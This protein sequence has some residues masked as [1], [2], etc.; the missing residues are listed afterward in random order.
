MARYLLRALC[1]CVLGVIGSARADVG[2]ARISLPKGPGSI[3]GL[4]GADFTAQLSSGQASYSIPV[5][6]PPAARSFGPNLTLAYDSGAGVSEIALGWRLAGTLSIRR[7]TQDG[8]PRFDESD[9]FEVVGLGSPSELLEVGAGV[10]RPRFEDGTF[11]QV[12]R[13]GESWEVRTKAGTTHLLGQARLESEDGEVVAYLLDRSF[14]ARGHTVSYEWRTDGAY[15]LLERVVWNDFGR[16]YLN[17]VVFTYEERPDPTRLYSSGIRQELSRRLARI[18]VRHGGELVRRYELAF[19]DAAH[20]RLMGVALVGSDG[21]T[22]LPSATFRYSESSW[23]DED[24]LA[25]IEMRGSPGRAPGANDASLVDLNGDALPDLLVGVAGDYSSALN[26]DGVTWAPRRAWQASQSPSFSL[27]SAGVHLADFDGDGAADLLAASGER[28]RYLA[29]SREDGFVREVELDAQLALDLGA[30]NVRLADF[31]GDRRIDIGLTTAS[32]LVVA[33]NR[34]GLGF[35]AGQMAR[36][37]DP[38][39]PVLF[40]SE[41]TDLCDINGDR[42]LDVCRLRSGSLVYYLGRGRGAFEAAEKGRGVPTFEAS[43]AFVLRDLDGDGW[44]DLVRIRRSEVSYAL[45]IGEG[46]FGAVRSIGKVPTQAASTRTFFADMNGSGSLDI[47]WVD[48]EAEVP[49]RYLE[50]FPQ[51][52]AGLL[53]EADGGL[54]KVQRLEYASAAAFAAKD[55]A[56]LEAWS[57]RLNVALPV[58]ARRTVETGLGDP[59]LVQEYE[60]TDGTYDPHERTFAAFGTVTVRELGD[61][62]TPTLS[63]LRRFDTGADERVLRGALLLE[64]QQDDEGAVFS[65]R[66][67]EYV[68]RALDRSQDGREVEYGYTAAVET[69]ISEG[70]DDGTVTLRS[71]FE[72]DEFGNVILEQDWGIVQGAR[73]DGDERVVVR[74]FANDPEEW[75]LGHWASETLSSGAG[76]RLSERRRYYDGHAF[77]G[78]ELGAV[79]RGEVT[80]E[81]AWVG[82]GEDDF[83]LSVAYRYDEHGLPVEM[84]DGRGGGRFFSWDAAHTYVTFEGVKLRADERSGQQLLF[85][86]ASFDGRF[87]VPVESTDY[88]GS[89]TRYGYDS[90][91]RLTSVV[92]PGDSVELPTLRYRYELSAPLSRV[93]TDARIRSGEKLV[94]RRE[95]VFDGL[96][97][98]RASFVL[99]AESWLLAGAVQYDAR[100]QVRATHLPRWVSEHERREPP[101][102]EQFD[103]SE[104]WRD[105]LG[106]VTRTRSAEGIVTRSSYLP[107]TVL[108]WDGGQADQASSF[109]H[110]PTVTVSDGQGRVVRHERTSSGEPVVSTYTYDAAGQLLTR[111]DPDGY[112]QSYRYDG[113]GRRIEVDDPDQGRHVFDY[114]AASN[115]VRHIGPEGGVQVSTYDLA[116]RLVSESWGGDEEAKVLYEY[117]QGPR[118]QRGRLVRVTEPSGFVE[119]DYDERG[120]PVETRYQIEGQDYVVGRAFDAQDREVEHVYPDG[121]RLEL[122]M[123]ARGLP[124]A[125]GE[126]VRIEYSATGAETKRRFST[127]VELRSEYDRDS[128]RTRLQLKDAEGSWVQDLGWTYDGAGNVL[129]VEDR[130]P[131]SRDLERTATYAYDN[132]QR[133][134][135][136]QGSWGEAEWDYSPSG[137]V[138][139]RRSSHEA[140]HDPDIDYGSLAHAPDT[141]GGRRLRYDA[142]GRLVSDGRRTYDWDERS[143]L[144]RVSDGALAV[145]SSY[146]QGGAR[147]VRRET[148]ESGRASTTHFLDAW[149]EVKDGQLVRYVVHGGERM[150]RLASGS[151]S[152]DQGVGRASG[153]AGTPLRARLTLGLQLL[154]A[155]LSAVALMLSARRRAV[156]AHLRWPRALAGIGLLVS[157]GLMGCG[158]DLEERLGEVVRELRPGDRLFVMDQVGSLLV[159]TDERGAVLAASNFEPF[160]LR[161]AG[162][163]QETN[164]FAG[165]PR[166]DSIELDH[167]GERFYAADLGMWTSADPVS[168]FEPERQITAEFAAAHAYAYA[169]QRP[170]VAVD[171]D[172][173][174]WQYVAAG[175][176]VLVGGGLEV[177]RQYYQYGSVQK[178]TLV[179]GFAAAGGLVGYALSQASPATLVQGA[180][181]GAL[182]SATVGVAKRLIESAGRD[183]GTAEQVL[184]DAAVGAGTGALTKGLGKVAEKLTPKS[185]AAPTRAAAAAEGA[186]RGAA[187]AAGSSRAA[188]AGSTL[189]TNS[190][191][192]AAPWLAGAPAQ[193]GLQTAGSSLWT[194]GAAQT[195]GA[196]AFGVMQISL[197]PS[198]MIGIVVHAP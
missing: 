90:F 106:R 119:Y 135:Q 146:G 17:E 178:W 50:L 13:A 26:L 76:D 112:R 14:D 65:R 191:A 73:A 197:Q 198:G 123:N 134:R 179:G 184:T 47:V 100:G 151:R 114:D 61:E 174:Y 130:R 91:G 124:S 71:E 28:P 153:A 43:E 133:L 157:V 7:R 8:L 74:T 41:G 93:V 46:S 148:T 155:G 144:R 168:L 173:R 15:P 164:Q 77:T 2:S 127:G 94:E 152:A 31:D 1:V 11:L 150:I 29:R 87:G 182:T 64:E 56:T 55:R 30:P 32:G 167:M 166:D 80:R 141:F 131:L 113:R 72:E 162:A 6:V 185:A 62:Y 165:T 147:R 25:L 103:P 176:G 172:G 84:R 195:G 107:L 24:S 156:R 142:R 9:A 101:L 86:A 27:G 120:N 35:D 137:N 68:T 194:F 53:I 89:V 109:E 21:T 51:G 5:L 49:W 111:V 192:A 128:K 105:A 193:E 170:L 20:P 136:A 38:D 188:A 44:D 67:Y 81:E 159:E 138:L 88:A 115:L 140:L 39:Q 183:P 118:H 149:S 60:Y 187:G 116:G 121:S 95:D 181:T 139:A 23:D 161:L 52:R 19:D 58:V 160:G 97:R 126:L 37:I 18:D 40:E 145:E 132:L 70:Q 63:T 59:P 110:T 57:S 189:P 85:E 79:E 83:E 196:S 102:Q 175:A 48:Q 75:T 3:E 180:A 186:Q 171:R 12:R 108:H 22:R 122:S 42:V 96:G 125:Y 10:F 158:P 117:D 66:S 154:L 169:N 177:M 54:G 163:S 34:A 82:P 69:A 16:Q 129:H 4:A 99:D 92:R 143:R 78:L 36:P 98:K 104:I 33:R 45:A 190:G